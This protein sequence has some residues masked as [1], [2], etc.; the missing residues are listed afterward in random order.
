MLSVNDEHVFLSVIE[1]ALGEALEARHVFVSSIDAV[2]LVVPINGS[3]LACA[4][5]YSLRTGNN[6]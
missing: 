4:A 1:I 6:E 5:S 3:L 2:K